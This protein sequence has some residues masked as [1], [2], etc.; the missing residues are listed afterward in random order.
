MNVKHVNFCI[1][2]PR[3]TRQPVSYTFR[4]NKRNVQAFIISADGVGHIQYLWRK[5]DPYS[6]NWIPVS[7]RALNDTVPNLNFSVIMKE[8]QGI[9]YCIITNYDGNVTSDNVTLTVFGR[10]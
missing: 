8:D 1:A 9:Y 5:Y 4:H 3:I 7:S 2:S 10:L 6:N